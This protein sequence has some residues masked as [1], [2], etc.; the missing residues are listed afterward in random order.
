MKQ[1]HAV[2]V[3]CALAL[4]AGSTRAQSEAW[5]QA[6]VA[7]SGIE[8]S[9]SDPV[10]SAFDRANAALLDSG[11][12]LAREGKSE[13]AIASC[14]DKAMAA[15]EAHYKAESR[16]VYVARSQ[17]E[18]MFYL[19]GAM[20]AKRD[21]VVIKSEWPEAYY[22]KAYALVELK[23]L[24]EARESLNRALALSPMNSQY[25]SESGQVYSSVREWDAALAAYKL[26]E[27]A[28]SMGPPDLKDQH[29]A[30]AWRGQGF[31]YIELNRLDEATTIF[32]KCLAL[33]PKDSTAQNELVY[34]KSL[35]D[36]QA[37]Q[38]S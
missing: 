35:R 2:I 27:E 36:K 17:A 28:A 13:E 8:I 11:A 4:M 24:P 15:Y 3:F 30:R 14:F 20:L 16:T 1:W 32:E 9:A 12:A 34:I 22:L 26:S 7:S 21:A 31:V 25:L 6:K 33:N 38:A 19:F 18:S 10:S 37:K 29:T 23:R 5:G